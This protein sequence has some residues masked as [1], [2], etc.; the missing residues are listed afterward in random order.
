M[1]AGIVASTVP[2]PPALMVLRHT[3]SMSS[4]ESGTGQPVEVQL[5]D[6]FPGRLVV[7][8]SNAISSVN[9]L[10]MTLNGSPADIVES[11]NQAY[12]RFQISTLAFSEG[13]EGTLHPTFSVETA[14]QIAVY[15]STSP[16]SVQEV[17]YIGPATGGKRTLTLEST[18]GGSLIGG[19]RCRSSQLFNNSPEWTSPEGFTEEWFVNGSAGALMVGS[20][21]TTT[22]STTLSY[23]DAGNR[24]GDGAFAITVK[25]E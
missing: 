24:Q 3:H 13:S 23:T 22:T 19:R 15:T 9:L 8:V 10:S 25:P 16:A 20:I 11:T 5:G 18:P 6:S 2:P 1:R 7:V 4:S 14:H 21:T 17:F 12:G